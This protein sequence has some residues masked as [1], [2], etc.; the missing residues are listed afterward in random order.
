MNDFQK[1]HEFG[2]EL[3]K[4][5]VRRHRWNFP[6]VWVVPILAAI[7]A[8]YLV[9]N[10]VHEFGPKI[11]IK[12]RDA[13]DLRSG[14]TPVIYRGVP[15]GEVISVELSKDREY[16][17]VTVRLR[18]SGASVAKE[19]AAFWIVRP[20]VGIGNITGLGTVITGP[21]IDVLPGTGRAR[22]EFVGLDT[23]PVAPERDGL[24]IVIL[25]NRLGSLK[26]NS[27]VYY[28]GIEVGAVQYAELSKD[29]AAVD[30][31]VYIKKRYMHLV[32]SGSKFW[33]VSGIDVSAGLFRGID[34]KLESLRSVVAGGIAFAT[35][36][37]EK[38]RSAKNG[39]VFLLY[40]QPEKEWL[41]WAPK[42]PISP[43]K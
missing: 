10:R 12:F 21:E 37:G 42:I 35:P 22:S 17:L 4:A 25:S 32:H 34:V 41:E 29:A 11:T 30:I 26:Q 38:T 14:E 7:V 19:G 39:M 27:P 28:R 3:P 33:N 23:A 6:I 5:I 20:E 15:V 1:Y 2:E 36:D 8:G 18:R 43:Q 13:S 40:N 16:A 24:H 31:H 9:Y